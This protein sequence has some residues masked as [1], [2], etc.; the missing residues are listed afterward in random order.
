M[1]WKTIGSVKYIRL[2]QSICKIR[3]S[4]HPL[5]IETDKYAEL[6]ENVYTVHWIKLRMIYTWWL[7]AL[8][9]FVENGTIDIY[10]YYIYGRTECFTEISLTAIN[11]N[12]RQFFEV[13]MSIHTRK[14]RWM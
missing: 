11:F 3:I 2:A 12:F 5:K 10:G 9:L 13:Y 6:I 4:A 7:N 1:F 8:A 14:F